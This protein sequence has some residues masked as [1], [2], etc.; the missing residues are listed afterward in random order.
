MRTLITKM[1]SFNMKER[2]Q[3]YGEALTL[4]DKMIVKGTTKTREQ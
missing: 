4:Y 2:L 1:T 3:D